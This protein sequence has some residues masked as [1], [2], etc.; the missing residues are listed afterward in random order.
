M[1]QSLYVAIYEFS[2]KS[3]LPSYMKTKLSR[4]FVDTIL[5]FLALCVYEF[6]SLF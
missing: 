1:F 4:I 5:V 6:S 2:V 3:E